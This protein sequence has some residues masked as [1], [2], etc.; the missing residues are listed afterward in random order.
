NPLDPENEN[1]DDKGAFSIY[2]REVY[3]AVL[4]LIFQSCLDPN[5]VGHLVSC[6]DGKT[7]VVHPCILIESMDA[8]EAAF[9]CV[10]RAASADYPCPKCHIHKSKLASISSTARART[11]DWMK[12]VLDESQSAPSSRERKSILKEH[13]LHGA[14]QFLWGFSYSDPYAAYAYDVLHTDD[15]GKFGYH[16]WGL[17]T[18]EFKKL[19]ITHSVDRNMSKMPRWPQRVSNDYDKSFDF[20]KQHFASHVIECIETK[21]ALENQTTRTGEAFIQEVK[22]HYRR[23]NGRNAA[24]QMVKQDTYAEAVAQI[25]T[26]LDAAAAQQADI[27]AALASDEGGDSDSDSDS[28]TERVW[29]GSP[30][31]RWSHISEIASVYG[32]H[33]PA[34]FA[35]FELDLR[36]FLRTKFPHLRDG[37]VGNIK[38]KVHKCL[39]V[40]YASQEDFRPARDVLR[41]TETWQK[42][43]PRHDCALLDGDTVAPARLQILARCKLMASNQIVDIA[44]ITRFRRSS[45]TPRTS[46]RG[47]RIFEE[48]AALSFVKLDQ[49]VRGAYLSPAAGGPAQTFYL[50]DSIGGA[51]MFLR[52]NDLSAPSLL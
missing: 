42:N 14:E 21:G 5:Q 27:D 9:Y 39:Y 2:K 19:K 44:A 47:C 23:T 30:E 24:A 50:H 34:L 8:E 15:L 11:V 36:N 22:Q 49:F 37:L 38:I 13:G 45:W 3:Q 1:P 17:L 48:T 46:F 28:K 18:D 7:R 12:A 6:G 41:C 40:D 52:L 33:N 10:C 43:Q 31:R 20:I 32:A 35:R 4:R 26:A 51:D 16:L 29:F 25:R